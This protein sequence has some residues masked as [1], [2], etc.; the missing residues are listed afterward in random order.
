MDSRTQRKVWVSR[1]Q[2]RVPGTTLALAILL[3][4]I[5]MAGSAQAQSY[6]ESVLYKFTGTDGNNPIAGLAM[7]GQ[8][9]LYGTTF[10]GG[11]SNN[12]AVFKVDAT[13]KETVLY[14]FTGG[15]DG[16]TP[17]GSLVLDAQGNLYGT[18]EEG[19]AAGHG[20]VFKLDPAG[21]ETVLYSFAGGVDGSAPLGG[22]LLDAQGNLYGTTNYAGD[23]ACVGF[24]GDSNNCGTVFKLSANG[25]ETVLHAFTGT[26]GDG[27]EPFTENLVMDGQGNLYGTAEFDGAPTSTSCP[28]GCGTV[29]KVDAS[30]NETTLYEFTGEGNGDG[31]TPYAGLVLDAQGNLYGTT[32]QGGPSA[33]L[34]HGTV[35][36]V[37]KNGN[38]SVLYSF[39]T[40]ELE[41]Y[42]P[43]A[44]LVMDAQ[45]NLYGTAFKGGD[46]ACPLTTALFPGC[47]MVFTLDRTGNQ[48]VLYNFTGSGGDGAEPEAG[49]VRDAQGNLYGTTTFGGDTEC[50]PAY[51]G[52]LNY[53]YAG[54]GTVFKLTL[55]PLSV[56]GTAVSVSPGATAGNTSTITVTPF[57]GFTG[58]VTLTATVTSSPAGARDLPIFSFGSTSP[59]SI[60]GAAAGTATLTISTTP[61]SSAALRYPVHP[62]ARWYNG[63]G[64]GLTFVLGICFVGFPARRRRR[65]TRLGLL[66]LPLILMGS[67]FGCGGGTGGGGG[68]SNPGTTP[69]NYTVTVKA[70]SG[71][72][73][74]TGTVTL[75]VE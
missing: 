69:G 40:D 48:T 9:N 70:T 22:L 15:A 47:G 56:N 61:A 36:K 55:E 21:T 65:R 4:A 30:G 23:A 5:L 13:G 46:L 7:D 42:Y 2:G 67:L 52:S 18:A 73:I 3:V 20:V 71:T 49:L 51:P 75:T 60:T 63:S 16:G 50:T 11:S 24:G 17:W 28:F 19:G 68:G 34:N 58:S 66:V 59:V 1:T 31:A 62:G 10:G 12:G 44:G 41:G 45:G 38:E 8:G 53:N 72:V 14:S 54:C 32:S 37:D 57:S 33:D 6:T 26:G 35:F 74:A 43:V 29:F 25:N 39:P 64:A 27:A